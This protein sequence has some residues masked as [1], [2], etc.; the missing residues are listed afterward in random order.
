M[1]RPSIPPQIKSIM[2]SEPPTT[3]SQNHQTF[4]L[5]CSM[6]KTL[7]FA[8]AMAVAAVSCQKEK[9]AIEHTNSIKI[10]AE[11]MPLTKVNFQDGTG[12]VWKAG[13]KASLISMTSY[14]YVSSELEASNI[15]EDGSKAWVAF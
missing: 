3:N 4:N 1:L 11:T 15:A 7:I 10:A 13:E 14:S 8:A 5:A 12:P 6:K 2:E 9:L